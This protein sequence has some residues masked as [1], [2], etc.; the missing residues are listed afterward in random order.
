MAIV[1]YTDYLAKW[2]LGEVLAGL[3]LGSF[4]VIGSYVAMTGNW[5][6]SLNEVLPLEVVLISL[7][8][9]ILTSLL[10]LLNEF[11]ELLFLFF[12][13]QEKSV[14]ISFQ[15]RQTEILSGGMFQ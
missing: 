2:L 1:F 9:G 7:P 12:L 4:V 13:I 10:L 11:P 15:I 5:Q 3:T 8:P 6:M 14:C